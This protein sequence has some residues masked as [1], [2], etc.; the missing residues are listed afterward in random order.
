MKYIGMIKGKNFEIFNFPGTPTVESHGHIYSYVVGP[1]K[2]AR[3]QVW[4]AEYGRNNPHFQHVN[5]A[6]RISKLEA[7]NGY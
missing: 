1:F 6:E 4:A 2:T 5:D 7:N 3:A